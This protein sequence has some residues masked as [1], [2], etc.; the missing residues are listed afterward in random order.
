M[1]ERAEPHRGRRR[2]AL[3]LLGGRTTTR[4]ALAP[5]ATGSADASSGRPAPAVTRGSARVARGYLALAAIGMAVGGGA[6]LAMRFGLWSPEGLLGPDAYSSA[7]ALHGGVMLFALVTPA[8]YGGLGNLLVSETMRADRSPTIVLT[9]LGL[10]A[11]AIAA[12]VVAIT[13]VHDPGVTFGPVGPAPSEWIAAL[14]IATSLALNAVHFAT[15]FALGIRRATPIAAVATVAFVLPLVG[16]CVALSVGFIDV[17]HGRAHSPL[18]VFEGSMEF[19]MLAALAVATHLVSHDRPA[20]R[21]T[22]WAA[23]AALAL[24]ARWVLVPSGEGLAIA[25]VGAKLTLAAIW[26]HSM[27]RTRAWSRPAAWFVV[28]GITPALVVWALARRLLAKV[29]LDIHLHDTYFPVGVV[30]L[31]AAVVVFAVLAGVLQW[32]ADLLGRQ[33]RVWPARIGAATICVGVVGHA[34]AMLILG[35]DGMPRRYMAYVSDFTGMQRVA[36]SAAFAVLLGV[37]ALALALLFG[38]RA[39]RGRAR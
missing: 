25:A 37:V 11:A 4:L 13:A 16:Q 23:A 8:L 10:V 38:E 35:Q 33:A 14:A 27:T 30:H 20:A 34:V 26:M 6:A 21:A 39:E 32:S 18:D 7:L 31:A 3:A 24:V 29:D 22:P 1:H 28:F 36:S 12:A 5:E 19:A 17:V 9:W 15:T 2:V